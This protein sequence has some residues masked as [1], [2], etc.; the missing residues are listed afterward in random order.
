MWTP[1]SSGCWRREALVTCGEEPGL[2]GRL[3]CTRLR[4]PPSSAFC[5]GTLSQHL[6][7]LNSPVTTAVG[8]GSSM[9]RDIINYPPLSGVL[10]SVC[11]FSAEQ[12]A[13]PL[14]VCKRIPSAEPSKQDSNKQT[15]PENL[16]AQPHAQE[17][18]MPARGARGG[19]ACSSLLPGPQRR[20]Y[21]PGRMSSVIVIGLCLRRREAP[22]LWKMGQTLA[23]LGGRGRGRGPGPQGPGAVHRPG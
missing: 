18:G 17:G 20:P 8:L 11:P 19:W 23:C 6:A 2:L 10:E 5:T 14:L 15:R 1:R 3:Q 12:E 13:F 21:S 16:C 22:A 9:Q 4:R 7:E